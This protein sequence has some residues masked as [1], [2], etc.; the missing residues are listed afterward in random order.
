ML[1]KQN[2]MFFYPPSYDIGNRLLS[3]TISVEEQAG[4]EELGQVG[5]V[6]QGQ[7]QEELGFPYSHSIP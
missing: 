3:F 5:Q 1:V 7:G 4:V 2:I 6:G